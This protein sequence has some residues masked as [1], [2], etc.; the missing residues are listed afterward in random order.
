MLT[1]ILVWVIIGAA[2]GWLASVIV[3][4]AGY[5]LVGDIIVGIIGAL[6]GGFLSATL[7]GGTGITGLNLSS[8]IVAF[9]G[10]CILLLLL[11]LVAG[12]TR[13]TTAV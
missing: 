11:R 4:G 5:G 9:I 12:G 10:A 2:A 3:R 6:I 8:F 13:R 7:L 1:T